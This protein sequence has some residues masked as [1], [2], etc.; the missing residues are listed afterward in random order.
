MSVEFEPGPTRK[1]GDLPQ[2]LR[3]DIIIP[4]EESPATDATTDSKD[5][6]L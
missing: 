3:A 4:V 1:E 2:A 6:G 5:G